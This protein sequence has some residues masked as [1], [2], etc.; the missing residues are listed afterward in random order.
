MSS[1]E[2]LRNIESQAKRHLFGKGKSFYELQNDWV[3]YAVSV[4]KEKLKESQ[5]EP[6]QPSIRK[7]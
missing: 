7:L 2:I 6:F 5:E 3:S 4:Y 1:S